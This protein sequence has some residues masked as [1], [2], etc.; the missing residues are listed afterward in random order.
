MGQ[1]QPWS[2]KELSYHV[3]ARLEGLARG[4]P[5][6]QKP[7]LQNQPED[8]LWS[9]GCESGDWKNHSVPLTTPCTSAVQARRGASQRGSALK[10]PRK[11][12]RSSKGA[13]GAE[14]ENHKQLRVRCH[15]QDTYINVI[16]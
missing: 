1:L 10:L 15:N 4:W 16:P 11:R 6:D 13:R 5:R 7:A 12:A 14:R 2:S 8:P 9:A 3:K